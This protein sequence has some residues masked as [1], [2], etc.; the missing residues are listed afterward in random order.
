MAEMPRSLKAVLVAVLSACS[1]AYAQPPPAPSQSG[2]ASPQYDSQCYERELIE[3]SL[4]KHSLKEVAFANDPKKGVVSAPVERVV[5]E[6]FEVFLDR[7]GIPLFLNKFHW[8]SKEALIERELLFPVGAPWNADYVRESERNLRRLLPLQSARIVPAV[9]A[10]GKLVALVVTQDLWSLRTDFDF[11]YVNGVLESFYVDFNEINLLGR[12]KQIGPRYQIDLAR[13]AFG[14]SYTDFRVLAS[15]YRLT[16]SGDAY[17]N[18]ADNHP[19]GGAWNIG[20]D[21]PLYTLDSRLSYGIKYQGQTGYR[22]LFQNGALYCASFEE[23]GECVPF[24]YRRHQRRFDLTFTHSTGRSRKLNWT[25]MYSLYADEAFSPDAPAVSQTS[26]DRFTERYQPLTDRYGSLI[27]SVQWFQADFIRLMD[28]D[29]FALTEDFRKGPSVTLQLATAQKFLGYGSRF[30]SSA[31]DFSWNQALPGDQL[32]SASVSANARYQ[33]ERSAEVGSDW[34]NRRASFSLRGVSSRW[35]VFRLFIGARLTLRKY[36]ITKTQELLGGNSVLRGYAS[37]AFTGSQS[38]SFNGELRTEPLR[39]WSV[40]TGAAAFIDMGDAFDRFSS[41]SLKKSVGLGLRVLLPQFN[42]AV[43]RADL[44]FPITGGFRVGT[45][46]VEF[47]Q[48]F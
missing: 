33:P 13:Q 19:E 15:D 35:S 29:T 9:D 24:Q 34:I 30:F 4:R 10:S 12:G 44:G 41:L 36:D 43:I 28:I 18:R 40:Y 2:T 46:V 3:Q 25:L 14:G 20:L 21:R 27:A 39:L 38:V 11:S 37:N 17:F 16:L 26:R 31:F 8:T 45:A 48:V 22:R 1:S 7:D 6:R 32:L 5:I 42:R 47:G 23:T